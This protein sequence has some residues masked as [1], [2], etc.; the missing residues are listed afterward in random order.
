MVSRPEPPE[1]IASA[2]VLEQANGARQHTK[3]PG[4]YT[5][6]DQCQPELPNHVR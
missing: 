6:D 4:N 5:Y 2:R 1:F 3:H